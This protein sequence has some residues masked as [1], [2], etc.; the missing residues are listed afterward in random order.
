M[1]ERESR[2][3]GGAGARV[4][5]GETTHL[6]VWP[7]SSSSKPRRVRGRLHVTRKE[8][9]EP[10]EERRGEKVTAHAV[11]TLTL[12]GLSSTLV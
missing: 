5:G 8:T 6:K 9:G 1:D 3:T 10:G 4:K 11:E 2:R 12:E 7:L